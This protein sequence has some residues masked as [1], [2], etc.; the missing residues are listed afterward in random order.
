MKKSL[1]LEVFI[2]PHPILPLIG[3]D[4]INS[5]DIDFSTVMHLYIVRIATGIPKRNKSNPKLVRNRR[6]RPAGNKFLVYFQSDTERVGMN[7][8]N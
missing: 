5:M 1:S 3:Y 8:E 7:V 2:M 4:E 6:G